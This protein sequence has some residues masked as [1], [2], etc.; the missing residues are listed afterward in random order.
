MTQLHIHTHTLV[1]T[2]IATFTT[3]HRRCCENATRN[4][5][6]LA[7]DMMSAFM[8]YIPVMWLDAT[9]RTHQ[10]KQQDNGR[11]HVFLHEQQNVL[12]FQI[13]LPYA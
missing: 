11:M 9:K 1:D 7:S 8:I 10:D 6:L 5:Y 12:L 13:V 3:V 2:H 4:C